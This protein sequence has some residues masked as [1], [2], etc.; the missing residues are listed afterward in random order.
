MNVEI[1]V[2]S[3]RWS[4]MCVMWI[5]FTRERERFAPNMTRAVPLGVTAGK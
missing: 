4:E 2:H 5:S 1:L 3:V